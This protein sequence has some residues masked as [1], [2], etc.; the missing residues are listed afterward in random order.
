MV[1]GG[2]RN[3]FV[4]RGTGPAVA[5]IEIVLSKGTAASGHPLRVARPVRTRFLRKFSR[6]P[7][8]E[9]QQTNT[10]KRSRDI[11]T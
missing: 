7:D 9:Q 10:Q 1:D 6:S 5:F 11:K 8:R 4:G 2:K 3:R